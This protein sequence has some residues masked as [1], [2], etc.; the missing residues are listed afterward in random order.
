[1][2]ANANLALDL[3]ILAHG[4]RVAVIGSRGTI[5]I[6]P[7]AAMQHNAAILGTMITHATAGQLYAIHAAI[8][9]GLAK[10]LRCAPWWR[11][12]IPWPR[13]R[14]RPPRHPGEQA[15]A[16]KLVLVAAEK[17][18]TPE[19]SP[20]KAAAMP[21]PVVNRGEKRNDACRFF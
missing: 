18:L 19:K 11:G 16:G 14:R 7:R 9:A 6:D 17:R 13:R 3:E 21:L 12:P 4:G 2:L 1:M 15:A 20:D 8:G 10:R 5:A